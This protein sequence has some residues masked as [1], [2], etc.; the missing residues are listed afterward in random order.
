MQPQKTL[1][2]S[3]ALP[4]ETL[5]S[6]P[7]EVVKESLRHAKSEFTFDRHTQALTPAKREAQSEV[8]R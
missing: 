4:P 3:T 7:T 2:K 5:V 1:A 8:V 6:A